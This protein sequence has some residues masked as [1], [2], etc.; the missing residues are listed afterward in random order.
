MT[1]AKK[2]KNAVLLLAH[3]SPNSVDD[4]PAFL[5]RVTGGRPTA[6]PKPSKKLAIVTPR[7]AN[8]L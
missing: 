3:G 1:M 7:S 2:H 4:V 5:L 6:R 8:R